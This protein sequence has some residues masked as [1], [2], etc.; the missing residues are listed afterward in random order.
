MELSVVTFS[1]LQGAERRETMKRPMPINLSIVLGA[2]LELSY[3]VA[4]LKYIYMNH[5]LQP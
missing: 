2:T 5:L 3:S 1:E 4:I